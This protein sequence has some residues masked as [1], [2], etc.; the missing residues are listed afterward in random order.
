MHHVG[1]PLVSPYS[2][3]PRAVTKL[4]SSSEHS[5]SRLGDNHNNTINPRYYGTENIPPFSQQQ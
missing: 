1:R 2:T 4:K 3:L 5:S